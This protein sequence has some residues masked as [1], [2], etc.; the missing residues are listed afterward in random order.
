MRHRRI[1]EEA[2]R[3]YVSD[4]QRLRTNVAGDGGLH[5]A[6]AQRRPGGVIHP[7]DQGCQYTSIAFGRRCREAEVRPLLGSVGDCYDNAICK[8]CFARPECDPVDRSPFRTLDAA[9]GL[10]GVAANDT[11]DGSS[12]VETVEMRAR[13]GAR[14]GA[15]TGLL[16][17]FP[18][19]AGAD[20]A[21]AITACG[22]SGRSLS[23][24][25]DGRPRFIVQHVVVS[26]FE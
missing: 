4:I 1:A 2:S 20:K 17:P 15:T 25:D 26:A 5:A 16:T 12:A 11:L 9:R 6:I 3:V 18:N 24:L 22:S 21:L 19:A 14:V 8:S 13:S 7:S 10:S 23:S